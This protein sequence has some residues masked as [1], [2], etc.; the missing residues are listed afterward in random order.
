MQGVLLDRIYSLFGWTESTFF[1]N[2]SILVFDSSLDRFVA[3][4]AVSNIKLGAIKSDHEE[5]DHGRLHTPFSK[6]FSI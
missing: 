4:E 6:G 3:A 1:N 5:N 2:Q